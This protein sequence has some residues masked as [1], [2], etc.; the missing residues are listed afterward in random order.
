MKREYIEKITDADLVL[1][2]IGKEFE[3]QKYKTEEMA[4][5]ALIELKKHLEG[6]NYYLITVC[7]NSILIKAGFP[8]ERVVCP[9][10]NVDLKQ[11]T[12]KCEGS[13]LELTGED[14]KKLEECL[15][16]SEEPTFGKCPVCGKDMVL[17][18]VY[19]SQYDEN[20]YLDNWKIYT[21]WLQGTLNKK[22]CVLELGM[23]LTF[24][25]IIRWPFEK[26]AYY[27]QKAV[28]FRVNSNLYHMT[29]E[30]KDKGISIEQNSI[31]WLLE[32]DI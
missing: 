2:G 15:S 7:T 8:E 14:R 19:A 24:P 27:N 3:I 11:C 31:D 26:V 30:L 23:D 10:G 12:N 4:I 6:K 17:N 5:D 25:S 20:G 32:K 29:E 28:F 1:I 21:K 18:N 13:L 22:L 16:N 9:C